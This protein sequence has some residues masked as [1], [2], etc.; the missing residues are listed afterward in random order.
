MVVGG[1]D[2]HYAPVALVE[3]VKKA[4]VRSERY[5]RRIA[6]GIVLP[7]DRAVQRNSATRFQVCVEKMWISRYRRS[8]HRRGG[9]P[10]NKRRPSGPEAGDRSFRP[11][12]ILCTEAWRTPRRVVDDVQGERPP[13]GGH[14]GLQP[15]GRKARV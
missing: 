2:D 13:N 14:N 1:V 4:P 12:G 15:S 9:R 7:A 6:L 10:A 11:A 5:C 3:D 8:H